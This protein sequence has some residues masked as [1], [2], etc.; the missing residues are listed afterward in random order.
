ML[1]AHLLRILTVLFLLTP[2]AHGA[3]DVTAREIRLDPALRF[4]ED[5][6]G[7]LDLGQVQQADIP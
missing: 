6:A 4:V 7:T 5:A 1:I 3:V 2:S